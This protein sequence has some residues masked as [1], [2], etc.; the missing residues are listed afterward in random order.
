MHKLH[1]LNNTKD[2]HKKYV[3]IYLKYINTR[4]WYLNRLFYIYTSYFLFNVCVISM[5]IF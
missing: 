1:R 3:F 2:I 5:H 4:K